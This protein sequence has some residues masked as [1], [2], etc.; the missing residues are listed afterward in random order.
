VK[1]KNGRDGATTHNTSLSLPFGAFVGASTASVRSAAVAVGAGSADVNCSLPL[2]VAE[3]TI[4]DSLT[5]TLRCGP[6]NQLALVMSTANDDTLGFGNLTDS[7]NAPS[8]NW[9]AGQIDNGT[10]NDG[11][12]RAGQVKLQNGNDWAKV[13]DAIRGADNGN[14]LFGSTQTLA[15]TDN[16]CP[17]NPIFDNT[18]PV[19]GF[20]RVKIIGV[21]DNHAASLACPGFA[22]PDLGASPLKNSLVIEVQC[23]AASPG[24]GEFGGGRSYN[25]G[26]YVRLV[27]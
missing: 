9:S 17:G 1:I 6:G 16:G 21:T 7:S 12:A 14:C 18:T 26:F 20:V 13:A 23:A 5:N 3:C 24:N 15:V 10:C 4:L 2:A 19:V 27:Q 25:T 8:G 22:A 11:T